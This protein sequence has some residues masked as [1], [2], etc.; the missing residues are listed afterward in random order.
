MRN[1]RPITT[2][3]SA[4]RR[5]SVMRKTWRACSIEGS[6]GVELLGGE[7]RGEA[8]AASRRGGRDR[9]ERERLRR[10]ERGEQGAP[11]PRRSGRI[12]RERLDREQ[13]A[14]ETA[15]AMRAGGCRRELTT[16]PFAR[17]GQ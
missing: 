3:M 16:E 1:E 13:Q 2:P 12:E 8:A 9:I 17:D 14:K 10:K 5:T 6:S 4:R 7:E 11:P 15:G